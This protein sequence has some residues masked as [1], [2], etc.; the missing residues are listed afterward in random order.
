M[1]QSL[2]N[3]FREKFTFANLM[4]FQNAADDFS[5]VAMRLMDMVCGDRFL[6]ENYP[7]KFNMK[8]PGSQIN[9]YYR[10]S[11]NINLHGR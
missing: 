9:E 1:T 4:N 8:F 10:N 11:I 2:Y 3:F 6:M 7:K 5:V